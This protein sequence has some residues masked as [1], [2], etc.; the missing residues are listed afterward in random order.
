MTNNDNP[1]W[2]PWKMEED[3]AVDEFMYQLW[4]GKDICNGDCLYGVEDIDHGD[5][6]IR[7]YLHYTG[8]MEDDFKDPLPIYNCPVWRN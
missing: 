2:L 6:F 4:N 1:M 5:K 3:S 7:C 8:D